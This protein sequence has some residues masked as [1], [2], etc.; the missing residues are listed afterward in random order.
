MMLIRKHLKQSLDDTV[1]GC[2]NT[3]GVNLNTASEQLLAYV[4]GLGPRLA[5]NIVEYRNANGAI[6][7]RSAL[8]K[9]PRLGSQGVRAGGGLF[10]HPGCGESVGWERCAS[11][12]V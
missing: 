10:T 12:E 7:S 5:A 2:V 11:R 9:V 4:S 1:A 8:K 3:V 6:L